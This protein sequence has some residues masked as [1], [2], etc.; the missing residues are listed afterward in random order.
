MSDKDNGAPCTLGNISKAAKNRAH[1]VCLVH[2]GLFANIRLNGV[3]DHQPRSC[4][5][6]RSFYALIIERKL[7]F[8]LINDKYP[9]KVCFGFHKPGLDRI[10]QT[11]LGS[12]IDDIERLMLRHKRKR[13]SVGAGSAQSQ[14]KGCLALAGIALYDRDLAERDIRLP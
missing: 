12:L 14:G 10:T 3:K 13:L 11:V 7:L 8:C 4:L 6:Y 5:P 9:V 1:L 2:V